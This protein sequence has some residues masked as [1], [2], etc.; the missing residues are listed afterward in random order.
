[1]TSPKIE[2]AATVARLSEKQSLQV[3]SAERKAHEA[4]QAQL[5]QLLQYRAEYE[6]NLQEK[7]RAGM[8]AAQLRD[9]RLFLDKLNAA[10]EQQQAEVAKSAEGLKVTQD[11]WRSKAQRTQALD[12]L[13]DDRQ[14]EEVRARDKL[15]QKRAD[16][17]SLARM[18]REDF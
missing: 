3:L 4:H 17:D 13:V 6:A 15:E 1:M 7:S 12:Q 11:T 14:R 2:K 16:D 18:A 5:D 10:I 9:Y 8:E